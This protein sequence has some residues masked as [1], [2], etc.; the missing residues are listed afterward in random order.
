MR[1][2]KFIIFEGVDGGGKTTL[3]VKL[4]NH[5]KKTKKVKLIREPGSTLVGEKIRKILAENQLFPETQLFLFLASRSEIYNGLKNCKEDIIIMDRSFLSTLAYQ[6][7]LLNISIE[8]LHD[9]HS[10]IPIPFRMPLVFILFANPFILK[11]RFDKNHIFHKMLSVRVLKQ[12]EEQYRK[13]KDIFKD[14][15][16]VYLDA[17]QTID[18]LY[19]EILEKVDIYLQG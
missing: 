8:K 5:L 9:F 19:R 18:Y 4:Y 15:K 6:S 14:Y 13:L 2:R 10:L 12:I 7:V 3:S 16:F 1:E 17:S 11:K